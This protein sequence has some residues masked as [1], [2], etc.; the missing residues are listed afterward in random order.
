MTGTDHLILEYVMVMLVALSVLFLFYWI[1]QPSVVGYIVAGIIAG[2]F[3]LGIITDVNLIKLLGEFGVLMLLF[4]IGMEVSIS[5]LVKNWRVVI[6]GSLLQV[7]GSIAIIAVLG[8][9]FDWGLSQII[10]LGFV[11]SL[12]S[13]A[14]ILS[15]LE[16][17]KILGTRVGRDVVGVLLAQDILVVPMLITISAL[18]GTFSVATL[19]VQIVGVLG[20][21]VFLFFI[22]RTKVKLPPLIHGTAP[23]HDH[24]L[25]IA[26]ILCFGA[27]LLTSA[28]QLSL[29]LGAFIGG[30]L[31]THFHGLSWVKEELR[32]F[33]TLFVALFFVSIGLVINLAFLKENVFFVLAIVASVFIINTFVNTMVFVWLKRPL[34]Y[35]LYV[36]A[37]LAPLGEFSFFLATAGLQI[38]AIEQYA[39]QMAMLVIALSLIVSPLWTQIFSRYKSG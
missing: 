4:F 24:R 2:P 30:V 16:S 18:G 14:V 37:I 19:A 25:F 20:I 7:S 3:G 31:A 29:G 15:F 8:H 23:T 12:S 6:L 13:T 22:L 11:M 32:T 5:S 17:K 26:L 34:R 35:S 36:G 38:G 39:Y 28:F 1:K 10:L 27:A 9:F 21:A 33:K